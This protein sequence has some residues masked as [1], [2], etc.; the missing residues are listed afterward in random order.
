MERDNFLYKVR[1]KIQVI[2]HKLFSDEFMSKIYFKIV[3]KEKLN[4]YNPK[5]FNEKLQWLKLNYY[6]NN[7]LVIKC[8][9][10]YEVRE[11]IKEKGYENKLVPLIGTWNN[12]EEIN[13]NNLPEKFVLKCN[14]GCA[15]NLICDNKDGFNKDKAIKQLNTWLKE[16]FGAFNIELHYSK[17]KEHKIICEEYLGE[18]LVDY[19]FFCFNGIPKYLYVSSDLIHDRQAKIGFFNIDGSKMK[20]ERN[21]YAKIDKIVFPEFYNEMLE[22]T[23]K[24]CEDFCFVRVDFFVTKDKYYFAELTFTPSACMMPF[25]PQKIDLEWGRILNI[26]LER[27]KYEKD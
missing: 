27:R 16:D 10:K 7:D 20:L 6:P 23:Q 21:D 9:D 18:D 26:D 12:A 2:A 17:I 25:N 8:A 4:L 3:L 14:H 24:L 11:Y 15:Y 19:K 13:W 5:T 22:I 1:R